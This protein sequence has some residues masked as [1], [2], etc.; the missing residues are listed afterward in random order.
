MPSIAIQKTPQ[1]SSIKFS[2]ESLN[3]SQYTPLKN[4]AKFS[5]KPLTNMKQ[6]TPNGSLNFIE[7][8]I[9]DQANQK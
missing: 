9:R 2:Q 4:Q 3:N 8:Q 5:L 1:P 6:V 7:K